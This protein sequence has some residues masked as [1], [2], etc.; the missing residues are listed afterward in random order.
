M[1]I[2]CRKFLFSEIAFFD[3]KNVEEKMMEEKEK[4]KEWKDERKRTTKS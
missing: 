1:L 2:N 4:E 3:K